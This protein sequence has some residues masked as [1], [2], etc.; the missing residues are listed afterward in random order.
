MKTHNL[1]I[2]TLL[3]AFLLS[4]NGH[5]GGKSN[6]FS[7]QIEGQDNKFNEGENL[8][9][10]IKNPKGKDVSKVTYRLD[11]QAFDVPF[12]VKTSS[13][14]EKNLEAVVHFDGSTD[15]ISRNI[16]VLSSKKPVLYTY[17]IINEYPHDIAAYTQGLEFHNGKLYE[18][19][20]RYGQ[21]SI[22]IVDYK[23]GEVTKKVDLTDNYFGEG[24]T[25]LNDQLYQLTWQRKTGFVYDPET[26]ER[27]SSFAYG[28]SKEGW[29][30]CNDGKKLYK[31]DGTEKI[32]VLNPE[33]LI[34]EGYIQTVTNTSM[35]SK[36]NE[37]E[38]VNGKIYANTY[39]KDGVMIIDPK[40]GAI[41]G[42]IDFST[43]KKKVSQHDDLDVLN[44]IAFNPETNTLFV[45]GKNW[46]KLFEVEI[47]AK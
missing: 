33:T 39:Q 40:T 19:T 45:T 28:K 6:G 22:R 15:T 3:A 17:K 9:M 43:L 46:N 38:Y 34:E 41:E 36:A 2:I 35:F 29:G 24:L 10:T 20:G 23:T 12:T 26:L 27:K 30:L 37:L 31:S 8:T 25:I 21:S 1:F 7:I 44:G 16:I 13:Y 42:V 32:W 14:G 5:S 11:G 4:C 18:S 47:V